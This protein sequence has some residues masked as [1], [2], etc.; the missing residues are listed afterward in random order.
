ML[1][2]LEH[3]NH[4]GRRLGVWGTLVI[5]GFTKEACAHF[6]TQTEYLQDLDVVFGW[7]TEGSCQA[8]VIRLSLVC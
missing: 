4:W 8:R 7:L 2:Y 1:F 6:Q 5:Q 3:W